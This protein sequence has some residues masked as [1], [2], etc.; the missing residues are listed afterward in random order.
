MMVRACFRWLG[1]RFIILI[2]V[3]F[4]LVRILEVHPRHHVVSRD[5]SRAFWSSPSSSGGC[6]RI[7]VTIVSFGRTAGS[8]LTWWVS[9]GRTHAR[10]GCRADA[11]SSCGGQDEPVRREL[12]G[13]GVDVRAVD[14]VDE[15]TLKRLERATARRHRRRASTTGSSW[16]RSR[17]RWRRVRSRPR[18]SRTCQA[19]PRSSR[20]SPGPART[21]AR[22][23]WR[24]RLCWRGSRLNPVAESS[25]SHATIM[26]LSSVSPVNDEVGQTR[27]CRCGDNVRR[28]ERAGDAAV[29]ADAT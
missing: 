25:S 21:A 22:T 11:S 18:S 14:A 1:V 8:T 13:A 9:D 24:C 16:W 10:S 26:P 23:R 3:L 6:S 5:P 7:S 29:T 17:T 4:Q 20:T 12:D 2:L 28:H 19:R 15:A 27:P